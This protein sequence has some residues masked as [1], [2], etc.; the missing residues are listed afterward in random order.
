MI[1]GSMVVV[2][3]VEH[4]VER[5]P[6]VGLYPGHESCERLQCT[7]NNYSYLQVGGEIK[8]EIVT[9]CNVATCKTTQTS[10]YKRL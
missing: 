9:A 7:Y 6:A 3:T 1:D 10:C 8:T 2:V 4:V 5:M